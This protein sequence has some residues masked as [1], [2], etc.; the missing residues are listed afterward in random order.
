MDVV[1]EVLETDRR[2]IRAMLQQDADVLAPLLAD[3]LIYIHSSS[4]KDS[5]QSYLSALLSGAV[6]YRKIEPSEVE[7][8][9]M[10]DWVHLTG[11][12]AMAIFLNGRREEFGVRF[13]AT[14]IRRDGRW[15]LFCWQSTRLPG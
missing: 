7:A 5:K 15:Q 6:L 4:A 3:D 1:A 9:E 2:R 8:R 14:Y 13:T 11:K 12:T 10:G